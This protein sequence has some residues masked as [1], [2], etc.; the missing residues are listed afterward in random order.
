MASSME[1]LNTL[2]R[3]I[4]WVVGNNFYNMKKRLIAIHTLIALI[5]YP[6]YSIYI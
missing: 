6:C 1:Q 4:I 5:L 2:A 3:L